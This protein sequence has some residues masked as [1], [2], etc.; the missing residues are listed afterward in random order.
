M[1]LIPK[2]YFIPGAGKTGTTHG[3]AYTYDTH[4]P[5]LFF[6]AEFKP[7]HYASEFR[8]TDIVPTLC[9]ALGMNEPAG[10]MGK[11]M[12][13]ILARPGGGKD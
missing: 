2:P 5:I 12:T 11:A 8:I 3:S 9:A 6:G 10:S 4:V 7:G 13:E 1:V